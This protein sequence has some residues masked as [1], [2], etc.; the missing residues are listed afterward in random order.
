[1]VMMD[2]MRKMGQEGVFHHWMRAWKKKKDIFGFQQLL[3][4][5][6]FCQTARTL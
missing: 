2:G 1:M 6:I 3:H 4:A 5:D